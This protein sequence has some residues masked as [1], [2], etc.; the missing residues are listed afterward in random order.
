MA[1]SSGTFLSRFRA[2]AFPV[3]V[4]QDRLCTVHAAA[5]IPGKLRRLCCVKVNLTMGLAGPGDLNKVAITPARM[6]FQ[7]AP[8][9]RLHRWRQ[10]VWS[11]RGGVGMS[12]PARKDQQ[13]KGGCSQHPPFSSLMSGLVRGICPQTL[14]SR[15]RC[16]TKCCSAEPGPTSSDKYRQA[17]A[18]QHTTMQGHRAALRPGHELNAV[19]HRQEF[20]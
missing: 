6:L 13:L 9:L 1:R 3:V 14:M 19:A 10:T 17:P 7:V 2:S 20:N 12:H 11:S 8:A 18:Q 4:V 15:T 16:S 5:G